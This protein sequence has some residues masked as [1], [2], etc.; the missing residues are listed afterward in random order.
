MREKSTFVISAILLGFIFAFSACESSTEATLEESFEKLK[1]VTPLPGIS[2]ESM[3][4]STAENNDSYLSVSFNDGRAKEAWCIEWNEEE[5][6][7]IQNGVK[8]YTTK[9]HEA[10][11]K[12]NYFMHIKDDLR[13]ADPDLTT[14]DIQVIIWALID[15]P[16]FDVNKISEYENIDERIYKDGKALFDVQKVKTIVSQ[17]ENYFAS[18]KEKSISQK[19]GVTVIEND[20]Q[21]II[22]ED[23]TAF[24]VM[25]SNGEVDDSISTCFIEDGFGNWGWT[26]GPLSDPS[27][28]LT[29]DIYAGAG[30]CD[31][32]KGT[33]VGELIVEY[34][35]GTFTATYIM[36]ETSPFTGE[37]YVMTESHLYVGNDPY[38][39][40]PSGMPTNAPG[41]Y[42]NSD[43]HGNV[44]TYTYEIEGLSGDIFFIAH[45]V[46]DGF[47]PADD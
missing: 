47:E 23:E 42:G 20:G 21:T 7:G 6:F 8:F 19:L 9:G 3:E 46:V 28:P 35:N 17:V 25:T 12:L 24:A 22:T 11:E 45:A 18:S 26:N 34:N 1:Q 14:K 33:L 16:S 2:V 10:W 37:T 4:V 29:F 36:T 13:A 43:D 40:G 27:G 30:Q 31:L 15:N 32:E 44:T 38:P 39:E 41:Q 5:A